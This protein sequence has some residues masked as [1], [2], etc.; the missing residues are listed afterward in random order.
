MSRSTSAELSLGFLRRMEQHFKIFLI[1][2]YI[3]KLHL[4]GGKTIRWQ[5]DGELDISIIPEIVHF[6]VS[7]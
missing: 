6:L 2:V 3:F 5:F 7:K 4:N 1:K